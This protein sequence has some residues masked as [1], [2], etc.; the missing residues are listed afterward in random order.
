MKIAVLLVISCF[1]A[2]AYSESLKAPQIE[3]DDENTDLA[4]MDTEVEAKFDEMMENE[5]DETALDEAESRPRWF[6][7]SY[8]RCRFRRQRCRR[9]RRNQIRCRGPRRSRECRCLRTRR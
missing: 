8:C 9:L 5:D 4:S 6:Y 2:A 3:D 7:A 1:I